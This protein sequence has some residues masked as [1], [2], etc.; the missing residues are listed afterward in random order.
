MVGFRPVQ[1]PE[2]VQDGDVPLLDIFPGGSGQEAP[3]SA[4]Y[5][6]HSIAPGVDGVNGLD[7]GE[8]LP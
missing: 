1:V 4:N 7:G 6:V 8:I 5:P 3:T 2:S